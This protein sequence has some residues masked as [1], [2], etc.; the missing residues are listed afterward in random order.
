MITRYTFCVFSFREKLRRMLP[1]PPPKS[2]PPPD[3]AHSD[4]PSVTSSGTSGSSGGS[5]S[6]GGSGSS[7]SNGTSGTSGSSGSSGTST[8]SRLST[9]A[10]RKSLR[11]S[12]PSPPSNQPPAT[13][14][15]KPPPPRM[16]ANSLS[17]LLKVP[18]QG[19][20]ERRRHSFSP[21]VLSE[22][23]GFLFSQQAR[24]SPVE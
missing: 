5:G 18:A 22:R 20:E 2:P 6:N 7:G 23:L 3:P 24:K 1:L 16:R 21:S 12:I 9:L 10:Q 17:R 14:A 13:A 19:R 4:P 15:A 8:G 11:L